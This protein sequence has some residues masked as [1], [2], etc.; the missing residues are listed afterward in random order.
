MSELR[1]PI[2]LTSTDELRLL[3]SILPSMAEACGRKVVRAIV[4]SDQVTPR[5][6]MAG[7]GG[8]WSKAPNS[9]CTSVQ[10]SDCALVSI[11]AG[12][13]AGQ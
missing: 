5:S 3:A 7:A 13:G 12:V 8:T 1:L 10:Q 9:T 11:A 2:R 6:S 4:G